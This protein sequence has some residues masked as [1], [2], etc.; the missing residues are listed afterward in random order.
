MAM[1]CSF[2]G[3]PIPKGNGKIL[4]K[5]SGQIFHFCDSK[6]D[7][8]FAMGRQGKYVKWTETAKSLKGK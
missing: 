4:V 1:K 3:K 2:C 7:K 5:N 8:N 6:C